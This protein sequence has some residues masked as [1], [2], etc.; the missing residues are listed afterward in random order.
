MSAEEK[1]GHATTS[2]VPPAAVGSLRRLKETE[3]TWQKRL[4]DA[5][6]RGE[7]KIKYAQ[8]ARDR[9][10]AD[11]RRVAEE[12]RSSRLREA[13]AQAEVE[14]RKIVEEAKV[15][16]GRLGSF[17]ARELEDRLD[18]ILSAVFAD[19]R[20]NTPRV[21]SEPAKAPASGAK[22]TVAVPAR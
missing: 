21:T 14:A 1:E 15:E 16:V 12:I 3:S 5:R 20:P 22:A 2:T 19:L 9:A 7:T 17:G 4:E 6:S 13:R 18:E 11:A 8:A 10:L